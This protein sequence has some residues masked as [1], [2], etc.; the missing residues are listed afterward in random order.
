MEVSAMSK[1]RTRKHAPSASAQTGSAAHTN[2]PEE[3]NERL[4]VVWRRMG[5]LIDWC[6]S[7]EAWMESICQETTPY[8]AMFYWE[9]IAEIVSSYMLEYLDASPE[10]VLSD[11]LVAA[12]CSPAADDPVRLTEFRD[13]WQEFLDSSQK[14]IEDFIQADLE[15]A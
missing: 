3:L 8:R 12:Q 15:L 10:D 1:K 6:Q 11:C 9:A 5:H 4:T 7:S 2:L 14:E 13:M